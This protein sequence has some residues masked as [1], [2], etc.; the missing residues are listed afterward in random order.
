MTRSRETATDALD[1]RITK[2]KLVAPYSHLAA[3]YDRL[4]GDALYPKVRESFDACVR[5]LGLSFGSLADIGC[6]T[7]R[8]L[9]DMLPYG[10]PLIGVDRSPQMLRIAAGRLRGEGV[11]LMRQDM[12]RL[13]LPRPVDLM[14]CNGDTL[15]YLVNLD[16]L[17]SAL[18]RCRE[19]LRPGGHLIADLLCGHPPNGDLNL[20]AIRAGSR[21]RVSL[22]RTR[23]DKGHRMTRVEI[24]FERPDTSGATCWAREIHVQRWHT[25]ADLEEAMALAGLRVVLA[26]P[27]MV[28][29]DGRTPSAWIQIV[30]RR[31]PLRRRPSRLPESIGRAGAYA[32]NLRRACAIFGRTSRHK[33]KASGRDAWQVGP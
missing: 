21:G 3:E 13:R 28:E 6:G 11:L 15:N 12:R 23:P 17:A 25:P 31:A 7:G 24:D 16:E 22:W 4:V 27:L 14:T 2:G 32:P 33:N 1:L 19:N 9:R 10:V 20:S 8:F 18:L 30:L 26:Q 5:A 29:R